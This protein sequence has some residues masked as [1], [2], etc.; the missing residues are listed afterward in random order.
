MNIDLGYF[1]FLALGRLMNIASSG[2]FFRFMGAGPREPAGASGGLGGA[3]G[4]MFL[5]DETS[6]RTIDQ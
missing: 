5:V 4:G 1:H 6:C 2:F 3:V